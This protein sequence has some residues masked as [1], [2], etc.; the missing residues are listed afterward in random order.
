MTAP[1]NA[2][3]NHHEDLGAKNRQLFMQTC[4]KAYLDLVTEHVKSEAPIAMKKASARCAEEGAVWD[5]NKSWEIQTDVVFGC[6]TGVRAVMHDYPTLGSPNNV[7][8]WTQTYG[9]ECAI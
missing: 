6:E 9:A 8:D 3:S 2:K 4:K 5:T 7:H 1:V